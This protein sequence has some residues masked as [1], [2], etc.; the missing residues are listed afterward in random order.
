MAENQLPFQECHID[1]ITSVFILLFLVLFE[2]LGNIWLPPLQVKDS[3]ILIW[4]LD[5]ILTHC[6]STVHIAVITVCSITGQ[7]VQSN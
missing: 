3:S 6:T 1:I 4:N 5:Q 2:K 7:R